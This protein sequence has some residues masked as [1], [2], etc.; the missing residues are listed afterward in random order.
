[1]ST[2]L[3]KTAR[4]IQLAPMSFVEQKDSVISPV[5]IAKRDGLLLKAQGVE[6]VRS[7]AAQ[8]VAANMLNEV[9]TFLSEIEKARTTLKEPFL[10]FGRKIDQDIKEFVGVI[11]K[12]K[13]RLKDLLSGYQQKLEREA[14]IEEAKRLA[15]IERLEAEKAKLDAKPD[16]DATVMLQREEI[17][18]AIGKELVPKEVAK[19]AGVSIGKVWK[20]E[21]LDIKAF[22]AARPDLCNVEPRTAAINAVIR[23]EGGPRSIPG[24]KIWETTEIRGGSR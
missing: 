7:V 5:G 15:E 22:Y 9:S 1:M 16:D 4:E 24:L 6:E 21:V 8:Q 13:S 23:A 17:D 20:F 2:A 18:K 14:T 3:L 11:D 10:T 19:P 12:E